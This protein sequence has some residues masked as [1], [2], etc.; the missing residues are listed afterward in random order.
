MKHIKRVP[1]DEFAEHAA[2]YLEGHEAVTIEKD[3]EVI[4]RYVPT[5]NGN[6]TNGKGTEDQ[7]SKEAQLRELEKGIDAE[8]LARIR[9]LDEILKRVYERTDMTEDEF[10]SYFDTT[11]PYPFDDPES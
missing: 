4:G 3:G 2:E 7:A 8:S 5:P 9:R 11:K 10:A 6:S 1:A